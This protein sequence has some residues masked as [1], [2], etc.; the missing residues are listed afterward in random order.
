[1]GISAPALRKN[2]GGELA[3]DLHQIVPDDAMRVWSEFAHQYRLAVVDMKGG[4]RLGI[5]AISPGM[6]SAASGAIQLAGLNQ[7][8]PGSRMGGVGETRLLPSGFRSGWG[9]T[10]VRMLGGLASGARQWLRGAIH[11]SPT[12]P[13]VTRRDAA[14]GGQRRIARGSVTASFRRT[15]ARATTARGRAFNV[16]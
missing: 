15:K 5:S 9:Q 12:N 4:M 10:A 7:A 8:M 16:P 2:A 3:R 1:M 11:S 14:R 6:T 13:F